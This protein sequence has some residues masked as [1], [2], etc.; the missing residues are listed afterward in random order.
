MKTEKQNLIRISLFFVV[1]ALL[2]G[3]FSSCKGTSDETNEETE[4]T[5]SAET[6]DI[7]ATEETVETSGKDLLKIERSNYLSDEEVREIV[8]AYIKDDPNYDY[9]YSVTWYGKFE[10]AYAVFINCTG[11]GTFP[12]ITREV[13]NGYEFVYPDSRT[14]KIY[15]SGEVY[16]IQEAFEAGIINEDA[17]KNLSELV[18]AMYNYLHK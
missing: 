6:T 15:C 3:F 10:N 13:V 16:S 9:T 4:L 17:V 11:W 12:V 8:W 5:I 1:S 14:M 2:I 7:P 18:T